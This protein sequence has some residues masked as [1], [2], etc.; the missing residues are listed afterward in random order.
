MGFSER[1]MDDVKQL[2][3]ETSL[4]ML[5]LTYVISF[6]HLFFDYLAF[7]NDVGF[8]KNRKDYTGISG[9]SL[10]SN[11][12][13]SLVIVLCE[14]LRRVAPRWGHWGPWCPPPCWACNVRRRRSHPT[15][16]APCAVSWAVLA[17]LRSLAT[18]D[19]SAQLTQPLH[20][21]V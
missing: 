5:A 9:R 7:K 4:R 21:P 20:T 3:T 19:S 13:C 14:I 8:F 11:F 6:A 16:R 17:P 15:T 10:L 2:I 12:V 18:R 1:D